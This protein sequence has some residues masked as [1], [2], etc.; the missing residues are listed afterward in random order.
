MQST[1]IT[2]RDLSAYVAAVVYR[3]VGATVEKGG[4]AIAAC[5]F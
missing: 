3:C 4:L 5:I 2:V 1:G